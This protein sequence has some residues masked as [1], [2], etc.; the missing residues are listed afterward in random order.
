[1]NPERFRAL[2]SGILIVGV[3][4]SAALML[5]GFVGS[6][7]V[8]W[9][10][11]LTGAGLG[12]GGLSDFGRMGESLLALRPIGIAQLGLVVLVATPV[13]RVAASCVAFA[14]EGDRLY[15]VITLAVLTILL[16]SLFGLR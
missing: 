15:T 9:E 16:V 12:V 5:I 8:G 14:L 4:T 10:G 1:V 3:G 2:V 11:S 13:L 6:L 7:L